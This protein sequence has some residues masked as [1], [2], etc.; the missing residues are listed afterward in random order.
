[1]VVLRFTYEE[2]NTTLHGDDLEWS[3]QPTCEGKLQ[4]SETDSLI[5][6]LAVRTAIKNQL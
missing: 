1:L 4:S 6:F 5:P 3:D 2:K